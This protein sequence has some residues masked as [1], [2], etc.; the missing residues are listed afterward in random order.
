MF[1]NQLP[2]YQGLLIDMAV[3]IKQLCDWATHYNWLFQIHQISGG[4][5][6]S[7]SLS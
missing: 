2:D 7:I 3:D 4:M 1:K 6:L 5:G